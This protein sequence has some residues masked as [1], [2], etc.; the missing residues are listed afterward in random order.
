MADS[1]TT[2]IDP[3]E[4]LYI[5]PNPDGSLN[6]HPPFPNVPPT[7][8]PSES[9][10]A[11]ADS[12]QLA[13]SKDYPLNSAAGTFIR[14]FKP[15]PLPP[16]PNDLFSATSL[17]F[18]ESCSGMAIRLRALIL[19]VEYRLAPE[20]RLPAAY[21]DA[22]DALRWIAAV[23]RG[24]ADDPWLSGVADFTRCFLMGGSAGANIAY[25]AGL[26]ALD[27]D[28][29]S[30]VQIE[31]LIFHQPYFGGVRRTGS[32]LRLVNDRILP[33]VANDL[34]WSL[35][36]P[37]GSDRDHEYSNPTLV[38]GGV[39]DERIG[40]LSRCLVTG[41]G[42]DPLLDRQKGF[43]ELL[44][45]SGAHVEAHFGEGGFHAVE[46]FD[47]AKAKELG[48]VVDRFIRRQDEVIA[49]STM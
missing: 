12:P 25:H 21:D 5:D 28:D 10:S 9:D 40:R 27:L 3:Y 16:G 13:L 24:G 14:A 35:A 31:G 2:S 6:R 32:E 37:E 49:R 17:P 1:T 42:G 8:S 29:L 30:P 22:V 47:P 48:D 20:H 44:K 18:H 4:V 33:L 11:A 41:H 26:R 23:A 34:M 15:H 45:G 43:V 19:S 7:E 36:L 46:L 38:N 39:G